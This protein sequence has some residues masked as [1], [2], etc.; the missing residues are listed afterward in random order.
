MSQ[1][2]YTQSPPMNIPPE[3]ASLPQWL[4]Y[5]AV[6]K[7]NGKITKPPI[8]A[9]TGK[10]G[11]STDRATWSGYDLAASRSPLGA[12]FVLT[13]ED[14]YFAIDLDGCVDL[15]TGEIEA[16]AQAI[17]DRFPI[18]WEVSYSGTGL[19]GIGR[20]VI[21]GDRC[22]TGATEVYD[23]D[24]FVVMTGRTL[25]GYETIRSCQAELTSWY[26]EVFPPEAPRSA[27][28]RPTFS[29]GSHT[30]SEIIEAA[31]RVSGEKF[32]RLHAGDITGYPESQTDKGF[33]SEADGALAMILV[34][35]TEH[36]DQVAD[37]MRTSGLSRRKFDRADYLSRT[38][39]SA[40]TRQNWWYEWDRTTAPPVRSTPPPDGGKILEPGATCDQKLAIALETIRLQGEELAAARDTIETLRI[41]VRTADDLC[42]AAEQRADRIGFER[43]EM[44]QVIRNPDLGPGAK[45]TH[46]V[47]VMDLGARIA[48]GE[49]PAQHG[50]RL[51]ATTIAAK[52]GQK[53]S[54]VRNHLKAAA[55]AGWF[56]KTNVRE[57][58]TR[59]AIDV[60]T[61]EIA[62]GTQDVTYI[63]VPEN[64]ISLLIAPVATYRKEEPETRGGTREPR[65][66]H[67]PDAPT[68]TTSVTICSACEV[69]ID[70]KITVHQPEPW[71]T[72]FA[73]QK[74]SVIS[75]S[76]LGAKTTP[77]P[78]G[79]AGRSSAPKFALQPSTMPPSRDYT[80]ADA[81]Y[82]YG[83]RS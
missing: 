25:P 3:L 83:G 34:G 23:H 76:L 49:E 17:I 29:G 72:S 54:T 67:H 31:S 47:T 32:R 43:S 48:N 41:R 57:P 39:A 30:A 59:E 18:Y 82:A 50:Y 79:G 80:D 70:R 21:P 60:E 24:R 35:Y 51:P 45:L 64:N 63:E 71:G 19:R 26:R 28:K 73:P 38:I 20:G 8:D 53:V 77:Q 11:S 16:Q 36:D 66:K 6:P 42:Q 22:R 65:C 14:P 12:G 9:K 5:R 7:P 27:P 46:F 33:S 2:V 56:T 75:T 81:P 68:I 78:P 74:P 52:S 37:I 62:S 44:M 40:R 10:A 4:A 58:S 69:E 61:G 55:K 15:E 1:T 13:R